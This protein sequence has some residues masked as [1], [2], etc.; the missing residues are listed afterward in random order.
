MSEQYSAIVLVGGVEGAATLF[1]LTSLGCADALLLERAG[2]ASDGT[3]QLCS[4]VRTHYSIPS[5]TELAV[6]SL[7]M[8]R[9]LASA[10]ED[11]EAASGFVNSGYL[12]LAN[13]EDTATNLLENLETQRE[14]GANTE[15]ITPEEARE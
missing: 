11:P 15:A 1:H 7:A 5:N 9:D 4:I 12:I 10:L 2:S 13:G 14:H 6:H 8:L 3:A